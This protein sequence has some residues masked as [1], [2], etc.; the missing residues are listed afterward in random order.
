MLDAEKFLGSHTSN[1][2]HMEGQNESLRAHCPSKQ[3]QSLGRGSPSGV[4]QVKKQYPIYLLGG[5]E[6]SWHPYMGDTMK[7]SQQISGTMPRTCSIHTVF[8]CMC[9]SVI[10]FDYQVRHGKGLPWWLRV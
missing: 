6:H 1:D 8:P 4:F 5:S 9:V 7:E 2:L 10:K 3:A